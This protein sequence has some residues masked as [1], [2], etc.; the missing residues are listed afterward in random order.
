M[1]VTLKRRRKR[2]L[3]SLRDENDLPDP[4][5][6]YS[7]GTATP[8][9]A[10]KA[11]ATRSNLVQDEEAGL[12][13]VSQRDPEAVVLP[14]DMSESYEEV[15]LTEKQEYKLRRLQNAFRKSQ[16][17]YRR[18]CSVSGLLRFGLNDGAT[19]AHA[20]PTHH[21]FPIRYALAICL[22]NDGN[23]MFQCILCGR[24]ILHA[25]EPRNFKLMISYNL[26]G[27][28]WGMNR[29]QRPAWTTGTLIPCSFL[30]GAC[31]FQGPIKTATMLRREGP[32][33]GIAAGVLIAVGSKKTRKTEEVKKV[34]DDL[35]AENGGRRS[36][37]HL[38]V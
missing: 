36:T 7:D 11:V 22:L 23:S 17:W 31:L 13:S 32:A 5:V 1:H 4:E 21:A 15:V 27:C 14:K 12:P 16:T 34:V 6:D 19:A 24:F 37:E 8:A 29:Y 30:C 3:N 26:T 25:A 28:M 20:T 2:G 33:L 9:V 10:E 38:E 18:E 35:V